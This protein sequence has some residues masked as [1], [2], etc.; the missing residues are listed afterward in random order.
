[1]GKLLA[2]LP[3]IADVF[4]F[5]KKSLQVIGG[6]CVRAAQI[7]G[8]V[9]GVLNAIWRVIKSPGKAT[10]QDKIKVVEEIL[11]AIG[12]LPLCYADMRTQYSCCHFYKT[13]NRH[14]P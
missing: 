7:R 2:L 4:V 12:L 1:M 13:S 10:D 11:M 3:R 8:E 6:R 14:L 5:Q 9:M